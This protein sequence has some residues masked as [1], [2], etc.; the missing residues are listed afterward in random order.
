MFKILGLFFG[1]IFSSSNA[2]ALEFESSS[3]VDFSGAQK[4]ITGPGFYLLLSKTG[5]DMFF[6]SSSK[7]FQNAIADAEFYGFS[8]NSGLYLKSENPCRKNNYSSISDKLQVY[9][10]RRFT[11]IDGNKGV[12]IPADKLRQTM[13]SKPKLNTNQNWNNSPEL[14]FY[15]RSGL[16]RAWS[17]HWVPKNY[18][19]TK[20]NFEKMVT[21]IESVDPLIASRKRAEAASVAKANADAEPTAQREDGS[22]ISEIATSDFSP[23]AEAEKRSKSGLTGFVPQGA[24]IEK[25][26]DTSICSFATTGSPVSWDLSQTVYITEAKRRGLSCGVA[27]LA[28]L[29]NDIEISKAEATDL[30][31][32][33]VKFIRSGAKVDLVKFAELFK[34]RPSVSSRW[35][36]KTLD[37]YNSLKNLLLENSDFRIFYKKQINDREART[38]EKRANS[39]L[40]L[41]NSKSKLNTLLAENFGTKTGDTVLALI[42]LTETTLADFAAKSQAELDESVFKAEK[43]IEELEQEKIQAKRAEDMLVSA[44]AELEGFLPELEQIIRDDFGSAESEKAAKIVTKI[45]NLHIEKSET[46][47]YFLSSIKE[48]A[49]AI[50]KTSKSQK[51]NL[52]IGSSNLKADGQTLPKKAE[53]Q[54]LSKIDKSTPPK[55]LKNEKKGYD[56]KKAIL[57]CPSVYRVLAPGAEYE[58]NKSYEALEAILT[59]E[60]AMSGVPLGYYIEDYWKKQNKNINSM[61]GFV[62]M[63][64]DQLQQDLA[65][66]KINREDVVDMMK[67]CPLVWN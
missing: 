21:F 16:T 11:E 14:V 62:R 28:R 24:Q 45:K 58:Y 48:Q 49:Q 60:A 41:K 66:G 12:V 51:G 31:A 36:E 38:A 32:D 4:I 15:F 30:Y 55:K 65:S 2:Y 27:E 19:K 8:H 13:L 61:N 42:Q 56:L 17:C 64:T 10:I 18:Q 3:D 39:E 37:E 1:L 22:P 34:N 67:M 52:H 7:H 43:L 59:L 53:N 26:E 35:N 57:V 33:L 29:E 20:S 47:S 63:L 9:S 54:T 25:F 40:A 5:E 50:L 46:E 44:I 23:T 6:A